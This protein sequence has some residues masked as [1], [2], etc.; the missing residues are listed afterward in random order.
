M[1]L[2]RLLRAGYLHREIREKG[3]AYGGMASYDPEGG[4]LSLL[5]YRDPQLVR[6][7]RVF[8]EAADW[9]A[10][11]R[12]D[13]EAIDE[14]VLAV[15]GDLDRPLAP[16]SRGAR[17][18]ANLRQDLTEDLRQQ[19]RERVLAVDRDQLMATAE[20]Y[21]VAGRKGSVVSVVGGEETLQ[22]ANGELSGEDKLQVERI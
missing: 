8:D 9:A 19:Q 16:G 10:G 14:A 2:A 5:S 6:T 7:L 11:G 18:F 17:E 12:F 3:G 4:L 21:L 13:T 15:F 1:V 20:R 22:K